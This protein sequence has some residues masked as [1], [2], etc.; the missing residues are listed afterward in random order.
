MNSKMFMYP[1][2]EVFKNMTAGVTPAFAFVELFD[3]LLVFVQFEKMV[4]TCFAAITS[5]TTRAGGIHH[6]LVEMVHVFLGAGVLSRANEALELW[7]VVC[8][9]YRRKY[10]HASSR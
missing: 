6:V 3:G 8:V 2:A 1:D 5:I 10:V 7:V 9:A 4:K